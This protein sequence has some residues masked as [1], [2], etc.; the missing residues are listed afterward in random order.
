[1]TIVARRWTANVVAFAGLVAVVLLREFPPAAYAFYPRCPIFFWTHLSCPGCG[2]TRAL[3]ALLQ[4]QFGEAMR[5]N[6][7]V[8]VLLP[9]AAVF[10]AVTYW[11]A[12]HAETFRWPSVSNRLL[13]AALVVTGV[14]TVVRNVPFLR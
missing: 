13:M 4:G 11:R 9:V 5:W 12:V 14:F 1:M 8:V 3:A 6:A 2:G 7:M 10:L